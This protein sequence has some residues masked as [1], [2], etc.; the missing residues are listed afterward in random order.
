M[1]KYILILVS[2]ALLCTSCDSM[3]D[4]I[5]LSSMS[6]ENYF[7]TETD[8]QMFS[9]SFYSSLL[10]VDYA[11]HVSDQY[12][13]YTVPD[14]I[15][16]GS[17]RVVPNSGGGWSWTVIRKINTMLAYIDN[18]DD[19]AVVKKYTGI[20]KFFRAY[21]YFFSLYRFGDVPWLDHEV[22]STETDVLMAPRDSREYVI[23]KMLEDIDEAI[24]SLPAEV[25]TFRVNKWA[26]LMLKSQVCL[27]EGTFRKYHPTPIPFED[28]YQYTDEKGAVVTHD[29]KYYLDLA[30]DAAKQVIDSKKYTLYSTGKPDRDYRDLFAAQDANAGEY[31]LAIHFSFADGIR[32]NTCAYALLNTQGKVGMTKKCVDA[33]LCADGSRFTD[34]PGWETMAWKDE[35]SGR[36]PRLSQTVR[37]PGYVRLG[38]TVVSTPDFAACATG[39]QIVKYVMEAGSNQGNCDR[40]A[41]SSNDLPVYRYALAHLNYAE[42]KAEA[43]T[44]TQSDLD[45]SVNLLRKR[46]GMPEMSLSEANSNPDPYLTNPQYGYTN[47]ILLSDPNKGVILEV[48]RERMVEMAQEGED[49]YL[50]LMRWAEG[51]CL[52]QNFHGIYFDSI[53]D[54]DIDGDGT[55]E[56]C[57]YKGSKPSS[58]AKVFLK[59][60]ADLVLSGDSKGYVDPVSQSSLVTSRTFDENRDYL[61]PIPINE[62]SLNP[63]LK[64]NPGWNDGL[65]F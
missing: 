9:N 36:D 11:E 10:D 58:T 59:V 37:C 49:R 39:Y 65:D 42:A 44:L 64:Q 34:K 1:K 18:C 22:G 28:S 4:K 56:Y 5:P 53:G 8:L 62:R 3:L 27:F 20:C 47:P 40:V 16:G 19:E 32:N 26:A 24:E 52:E 60:G 50:G 38:E 43:G 57:F 23:T 29:Y 13:G 30:A 6:P 25:S 15:R 12:I 46:A 35:M 31:I 41:M 63:N 55:V 17:A 54:I 48:R 45:F 2:A 33:Y 61:Y 7:L 14:Y 21:R 51:K